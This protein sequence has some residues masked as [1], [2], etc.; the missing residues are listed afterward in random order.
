M[1]LWGNYGAFGIKH[2]PRARDGYLVLINRLDPYSFLFLHSLDCDLRLIRLRGGHTNEPPAAFFEESIANPNQ[3]AQQ[4]E[5]KNP[6]QGREES[7]A[8]AFKTVEALSVVKTGRVEC[9]VSI[10]H[11]LGIAL[12]SAH[13]KCGWE[14][15]PFPVSILRELRTM[16][17]S[18]AVSHAACNSQRDQ[19]YKYGECPPEP[20]FIFHIYLHL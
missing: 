19:N 4:D 9:I 17:H 12:E 3:E 20:F 8:P 5:V 15:S 16:E 14:L 10:H 7:A 6:K 13:V 18:H 11:A 2:P 1:E